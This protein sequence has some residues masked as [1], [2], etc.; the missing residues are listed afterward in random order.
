M[1]TKDKTDIRAL[2]KE[3]I[4]AFFT[5]KGEPAFRANQVYQWLWQKGV[6]DFESMTN[7]SKSL[8]DLLQEHFVINHINIDRQQRSTDGTLK[9]AIKLH[10]GY[11]VE[12][13]LIPTKTRSTACVSSQVGCS[14]DCTF[15]A[16][17]ALK[18]MR[19]LNADESMTKWWPLINRADCI[20]SVH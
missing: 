4:L 5:E 7:L 11:V 15:C 9:N 1:D 17:A 14:L 13:V 8:R 19:N 12:S 2:S 10:D 6:H 16:T 18:R 3:A 20:S